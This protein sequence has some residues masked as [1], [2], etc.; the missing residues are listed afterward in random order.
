MWKKMSVKGAKLRNNTA[1]F[2]D[3]TL[4]C[5]DRRAGA[6]APRNG[7]PLRWRPGSGS[8]SGDTR[9][10]S[11]P[12]PCTGSHTSTSSSTGS[13]TCPSSSTGSRSGPGSGSGNGSSSG[14]RRRRPGSN[15]GGR[16]D[17][18][19][20]PVREIAAPGGE[21]VADRRAEALVLRYRVPY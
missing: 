14:T 3:Q 10:G 12:S 1:N 20:E 7:R 6:V 18:V 21:P 2:C 19:P 17:W 4:A 9:V 5:P 15:G 13:H 11:R 8:R 16:L